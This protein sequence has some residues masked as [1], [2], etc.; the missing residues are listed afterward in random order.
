MRTNAT[1]KHVG[2][3]N[4]VDVA[5]S[6]TKGRKREGEGRGVVL[7]L[8]RAGVADT[9]GGDGWRQKLGGLGGCGRLSFRVYTKQ[10]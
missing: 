6:A 5:S 4:D 10:V 9:G 8:R 7:S 1:L 2:M 3:V